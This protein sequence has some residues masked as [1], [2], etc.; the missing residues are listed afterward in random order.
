MVD[1]C[2]FKTT[3]ISRV[4]YRGASVDLPRKIQIPDCGSDTELTSY[5]AISEVVRQW[6]KDL[7]ELDNLKKNLIYIKGG[8]DH[9]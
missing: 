9:K 8:N 3:T 2:A 7:A 1:S 4:L 5:H 6:K